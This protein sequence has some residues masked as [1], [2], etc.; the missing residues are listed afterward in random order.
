MPNRRCLSEDRGDYDMNEP[1][2]ETLTRRLDKVERENRRMKQAGV[3]ALVV[4]AAVV[5]MEQAMGGKEQW[6]F[7]QSSP[8]ASFCI[9]IRRVAVWCYR[10]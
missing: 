9:G 7:P 6:L 5:L 4:I 8:G 1:T 10:N 2:I 3:V